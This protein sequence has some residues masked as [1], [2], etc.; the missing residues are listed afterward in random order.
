[1]VIWTFLNF[2]AIEF[3]LEHIVILLAIDVWHM[4]IFML[5]KKMVK[6]IKQAPHNLLILFYFVNQTSSAI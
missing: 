6:P 4:S 5:F 1:M 2:F 3:Y